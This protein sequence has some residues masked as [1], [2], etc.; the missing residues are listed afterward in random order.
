MDKPGLFQDWEMW[1]ICLVWIPLLSWQKSTPS[2]AIPYKSYSICSPDVFPVQP[3]VEW[4]P[5]QVPESGRGAV[6]SC[7][8]V[9]DIWHQHLPALNTYRS[10]ELFLIQKCI[11]FDPCYKRKHSEKL[12]Y[13]IFPMLLQL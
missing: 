10:L 3:A 7:G 8:R 9:S 11:F 2:P 6:T 5:P 12:F 4:G 1:G 13:F